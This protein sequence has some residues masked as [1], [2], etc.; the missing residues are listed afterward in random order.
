MTGLWLSESVAVPFQLLLGGFAV[1]VPAGDGDVL[2]CA[3]QGIGDVAVFHFY[4]GIV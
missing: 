3:G 1:F 4:A 2:S